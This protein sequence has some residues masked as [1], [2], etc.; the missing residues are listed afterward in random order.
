MEKKVVAARNFFYLS[1]DNT[2][3][4]SGRTLGAKSIFRC[5]RF[6]IQR[7]FSFFFPF[8]FRRRRFRFAEGGV[9]G[10]SQRERPQIGTVIR[11]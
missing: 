9:V 10:K 7:V 4:V 2:K 5:S 3:I 1:E 6:D 8:L 11:S